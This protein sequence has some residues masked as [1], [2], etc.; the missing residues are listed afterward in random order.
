MNS[1]FY[2]FFFYIHKYTS[3]TDG[4][5]VSEISVNAHLAP[6]HGGIL[7]I[8]ILYITIPVAANS[9]NIFYKGCAVYYNSEVPFFFIH[10]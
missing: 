7:L 3:Y 4:V 5:H 2:T 9:Y 8:L 6:V 10:N 1:L